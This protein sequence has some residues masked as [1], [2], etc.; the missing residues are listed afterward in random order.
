MKRLNTNGFKHV[1]TLI[2]VLVLIVF[3]VTVTYFHHKDQA[4]S[5]SATN[6]AM[7]TNKLR[8]FP[9]PYAGWKIY[10]N[11]QISLKYP[12]GWQV[13]KEQPSNTSTESIVT[14]PG[15]ISNNLSTGSSSGASI[16]LSLQVSTD[17]STAN[18]CTGYTCQVIAVLACGSSQLPN[19]SLAIVNET[20]SSGTAF[21]QYIVVESSIKVG[22]T[23]ITPLA[24]GHNKL[25]I[26]GQPYYAPKEGGPTAA[27]I[28][29]VSGLLS[30]TQ[31]S[32][33]ISMINS[34]GFK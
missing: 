24:F 7:N 6:Q 22:D 27:R 11:D 4:S 15:F 26:F 18:I 1:E 21:S 12:S 33:L 20:S 3:S 19:A 16:R 2:V 34:I 28:T 31:Y 9:R 29:N 8:L 30:E 5:D 10:N 32:N 23:S 14:S 13:R 25:Y 17:S